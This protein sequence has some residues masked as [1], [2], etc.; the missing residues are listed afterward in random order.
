MDT[1]NKKPP[2]FEHKYMAHALG[3]YK[4]YPL[5][6]NEIAFR[7]SYKRG[8]RYF[9][10]DIKV[11]EDDR[12][13]C[14]Y[15]WRPNQCER[16]GMKYNKRF[17]KMTYDLF[18]KQTVHGMPVMDAETLAALMIEYKDTYLEIDLKTLAGDEAVFEAELIYDLFSEA[19]LL[20]RI[21]IQANTEEM[22]EAIKSV[23][24]FPYIQFNLREDIENLDSYIDFCVKNNIC[25]IALKGPYVKPDILKKIKDAGI[26]TLVYTVDSR[27]RALRYLNVGADTICTNHLTPEAPVGY[28]DDLVFIGYHC[29]GNAKEKYSE[30]SEKNILRCIFSTLPDGSYYYGEIVNSLDCGVYKLTGCLY[31]RAFHSFKG[32]QLRA[33]K[34]NEK[35]WLWFCTDEQWHTEEE[36]ISQSLEKR[37]FRDCEEIDL[38]R[39]FYRDRMIFEACW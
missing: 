8:F 35:Q 33:K 36:L 25:A 37:L 20:D 21:L 11:T 39:I 12:L 3:S 23:Y 14:S 10:T 4:G 19:G 31:K 6:N 17:K 27:T 15:G 22:F 34:G 5:L 26:C 9:E 30:L 16:T 24:D 18:M 29:E 1:N 32:W 2:M 28:K 13:I 7:N 38:D